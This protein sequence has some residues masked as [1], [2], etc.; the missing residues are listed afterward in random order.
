[1]GHRFDAIADEEDGGYHLAG[2]VSAVA[3]HDITETTAGFIEVVG[4][5]STESANSAEAYLNTGLTLAIGDDWQL[6]GGIRVGL[7]AASDDL[8]PFLGLSCRF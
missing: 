5:L 7:T 1:M 4:I 8:T 3:G 2:L 6:D